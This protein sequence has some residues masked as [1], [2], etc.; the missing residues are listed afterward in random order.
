MSRAT[1]KAV[2]YVE[3]V[4]GRGNVTL[5]KVTTSQW[6]TV[7]QI[8]AS[9]GVVPQT[10]YRQIVDGGVM[11]H[12]RVGSQIRVKVEDFAAWLEACRNAEYEKPGA[13]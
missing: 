10:M 5:E 12:Y 7:P 6:V 13:K 8:A 4:D 9:V 2:I 11:P 3:R 1:Y